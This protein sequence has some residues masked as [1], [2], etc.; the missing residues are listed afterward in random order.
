MPGVLAAVPRALN[1]TATSVLPLLMDGDALVVLVAD[2]WDHA[3]LDQLR[4]AT[5]R[6]IRPLD[7]A[8]GSLM[9]AVHR[10]Y[11][12][13]RAGRHGRQQQPGAQQPAG[14]GRAAAQCGRC[15]A[16]GRGRWPPD[17]TTRW[18]A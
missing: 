8:A 10:A 13:G 5:Q 15:H 7:G 11:A 2:P 4:F 14:A 16:A 18:C 17:R 12:G 3:L 6:R 1:E 9:P